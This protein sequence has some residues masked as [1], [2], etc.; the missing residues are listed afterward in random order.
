MIKIKMMKINQMKINKLPV[1]NNR[2]RYLFSFPFIFYNLD[3]NVND[4]DPVISQLAYGVFLLS[5]IAFFLSYKYNRLW[6]N[7]LFSSKRWL[8]IK[9]P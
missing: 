6:F 5:L 8:W 9:I 2:T 1:E 7:L 3:I 4:S